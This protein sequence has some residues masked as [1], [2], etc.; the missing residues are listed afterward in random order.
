MARTQTLGRKLKAW[1]VG[2]RGDRPNNEALASPVRSLSKSAWI[3]FVWRTPR[4]YSEF[5][6]SDEEERKRVWGGLSARLLGVVV[7]KDQV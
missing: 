4:V 5:I 3:E 7:E 1:K 6:V 2:Q